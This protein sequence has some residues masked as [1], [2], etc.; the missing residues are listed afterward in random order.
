MVTRGR[1]HRKGKRLTGCA[2]P[3]LRSACGHGIA[4]GTTCGEPGYGPGVAVPP[5]I[6][7]P[8]TLWPFAVRAYALPGVAS[9][10]L[11]LQDEHGLDVDVVLACLWVAAHGG[12]LDDA[13]LERMLAAAAP[14]R[15]R[16]LELRALRRAAGSDREHDPRAQERYAQLQATELSAERVELSC[17]EATLAAVP[18]PDAAAPAML[19]LTAL[20][21]Y[22][23]S[24][25][26]PSCDPLLQALVDRVLPRCAPARD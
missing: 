4:R 16:V 24:R 20:R 26:E 17:I 9:L 1:E 6:E 19:A 2:E 25:G 5:S 13:D 18:G 8:A 10:C 15:A 23:A 11:R 22:A 14:A 3:G 21:R 12:A 7:L